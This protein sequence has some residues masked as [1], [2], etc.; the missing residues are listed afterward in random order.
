MLLLLLVGVSLVLEPRHRVLLL[1]LLLACKLRERRAER[2]GWRVAVR[3]E[4]LGW[5]LLVR[6]LRHPRQSERGAIDR[7][8]QDHRHEDL[9]SPCPHEHGQ[10]V[11]SGRAR[12]SGRT[13]VF[14]EMTSTKPLTTSARVSATTLVL[15]TEFLSLAMHCSQPPQAR[16]I[17]GARVSRSQKLSTYALAH[18]SDSAPSSACSVMSRART[19]KYKVE[20]KKT[21]IVTATMAT[22]AS[23]AKWT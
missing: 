18:A 23:E 21:E 4:D 7:H 12:A 10:S 6:R 17:A 2:V 19:S 16:S 9:C 20:R 15:E 8:A 5:L 14:H 1:L 3:R 11:L 22:K 13:I